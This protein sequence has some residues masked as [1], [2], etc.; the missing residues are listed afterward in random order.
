MR[1]DL[2]TFAPF[3][4][5]PQQPQQP[6]PQPQPPQA[7]QKLREAA[8]AKLDMLARRKA[9]SESQRRAREA[10][11]EAVRAGCAARGLRVGW[12]LFKGMRRTPAPPYIDDMG[13]MV[14][15]VVL[16]YPEFSQSDFVEQFSEVTTF[17]DQLA[18]VLP[19]RG[20]GPAWDETHGS[21]RVSNLRVLFQTNMGS[22][23]PLP[24]AWR[25]DNDDDDEPTPVY[26]KQAWIEV[27]LDAPLLLPL[28]HP[29]YVICDVPVFRV[30]AKGSAREAELTRGLT[31][32]MVVPDLPAPPS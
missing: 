1:F 13:A 7:L 16:L 23:R 20:P 15:P 22:A 8:T 5:F 17:R 26:A 21:Y 18:H 2:C 32:R 25:D 3:L 19:D 6:Q 27:P 24:K 30:V 31:G 9:E 14:W 12:P 11:L 10:S 29:E 28:T 4:L